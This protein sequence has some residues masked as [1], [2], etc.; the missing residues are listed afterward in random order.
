MKAWD[1]ANQG[2]RNKLARILFQEVWIKDK[3]VIAVRPQ[4]EF[5]QFFE[6]NYEA[7]VNL[8][9]EGATPKGIGVLCN[10]S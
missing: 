8:D 2:L 9:Y 3:Q 5:E 6:L 7:Y 4:P 1:A 10:I